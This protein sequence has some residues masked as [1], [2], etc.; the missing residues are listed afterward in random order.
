MFGSCYSRCLFCSGVLIRLIGAYFYL[1]FI[2]QDALSG[3]WNGHDDSSISG[4]TC[5]VRILFLTVINFLRKIRRV[6]LI[7]AV[8]RRLTSASIS[9]LCH[10]KKWL[11][12]WLWIL[13]MRHVSRY[14]YTIQLN[15]TNLIISI[16]K[17]FE[18]RNRHMFGKF[19]N[20]SITSLQK[21]N[22]YIKTILHWEKWFWKVIIPTRCLL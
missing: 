19:L 2:I 4:T 21:K 3:A 1:P 14:K 12:T 15:Y 10:R 20:I 17:I 16:Y 8:T 18:R 13:S 22:N 7:I 9:M 11:S 6:S 5:S